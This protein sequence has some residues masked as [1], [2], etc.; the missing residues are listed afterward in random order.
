M[1]TLNTL[2]WFLWQTTGWFNHWTTTSLPREQF[3][4]PCVF[5]RIFFGKNNFSVGSIYAEMFQ[6][7][8]LNF[9][10]KSPPRLL[11]PGT[12]TDGMN[13]CCVLASILSIVWRPFSRGFHVSKIGF[14]V[15]VASLKTKLWK[16]IGVCADG[17]GCSNLS[18]S[19]KVSSRRLKMHLNSHK[20]PF[21]GGGFK[22]SSFKCFKH[23]KMPMLAFVKM[24]WIFPPHLCLL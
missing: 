15:F 7:I 23:A 8:T 21:L 20:N 1:E 12:W 5:Y 2:I 11:V 6:N 3:V 24:G 4:P 17:R 16:S 10:T 19:P 22:W 9:D 13:S 18:M 14:C